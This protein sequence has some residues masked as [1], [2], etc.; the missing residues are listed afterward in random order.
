MHMSVIYKQ[1]FLL[2][3]L[4]ITMIGSSRV[5]FALP[6]Q[7]QDELVKS[8]INFPTSMT[9]MPDGR[10]LVTEKT[11]QIWILDPS[12][13]N[14]VLEPYLLITNIDTTGERGLL[15][16]VLDPGFSS[17]H[18]VYVSYH[19]SSEKRIFISRFTDQG[20]TASLATEFVV[21][22]DP[23]LFIDAQ[24]FH[25]GGGLSF[26]PDG[27]LYLATGYHNNTNSPQDLTSSRGKIIRVAS[28]GSIPA[29][30]PFIDG[31]GGNLDEI[32]AYGLRNPWRARWDLQGT[33]SGPRLFIGEVG[34]NN[35]NTSNEDI[36]IGRKGA[37]YGW[38]A[39]EGNNDCNTSHPQYDPNQIYDAP[40][41]TYEHAGGEAAVMGG[42]VY[43]GSQF[44]APFP[45]AYFYGDYP[46]Q[47]LRYLTFDSNGA[48]AT[49][50]DFHNSAG[51]VVDIKQG[52]DG[53][54]YYIQIAS[55][56][57]NFA[58]NSGALR[59]IRFNGGNQ[60]PQITSATANVTVGESPL[61]VQFSG[62]AAD[63]ENDPLSFVW[64]FGD[65]IQA[66]GATATHDYTQSGSYQARLQVSD[67]NNITT[68]DPPIIITV[69]SKPVVTILEP[70]DGSLFRAGGVV[71]FEASATDADGVLTENSY[72]WTINLAHNQH[73]HPEI[74]PITG[75][76]GSF[77]TPDSDHSYFDDT[78]FLITVEVTDSDGISTI[79][80]VRIEPEE[81][82]ITFNTQPAG[83]DIFID[84]ETLTS[85]FVYDS[86]I[87][88]N[89]SITAPQTACINDIQYNFASW[90]NGAAA[91]FT[92]A[93]PNQNA[94]LTATYTAGGSCDSGG[95]GVCGQNVEM[96]GSNDWVNIP[97]TSFAGDF[98]IEGWVKLAPGID[99][100]D[101]FIGQEGR[102]FD[103][104]FHASLARLYV[105][106]DVV[107]ANTPMQPNTWTHLA[108]TRSGTS[109]SL[110]LNGTLDATGNWN[111]TLPVQAL[112]R[113]NRFSR[114]S[115][116]GEMDE[117]RFWDVARS[118][119]QISQNYT[120]SVAPNSTGLVGYWTFNES[121]QVVADS[122]G[123]GQNGSLG[124]N[125]SAGND[126]PSRIASTA[127]FNENCGGPQNNAPIAQND[128]AGPIAVAATTTIQVLNNDSDS[129]GTLDTGSVTIVNSP[130][131]G[132]A[133]VL[134]SG[135]I[136]YTHDGS[137]TTTDQLTYT[138]EDN[139]GAISNQA[140]VSITVTA[141]T[142][143]LPPV[144]QDDTA[145]PIAVAATTTIQ[146]LNND[147]DSDG[148][149]DTNSVT[150]V[151]SPTNGT[152]TVLASG[153]I[154]Y[155]HDGSTTTTDQLTYT[156]EDNDGAVSNQATV[157]VTITQQTASCGMST[158]F[159]GSND[160][161][162]IPDTSFADDFTIEGWV[163]LAPG[164]DFKDAFIGQ[165][166][167]GPDINFHAGKARLFAGTDR[168]VANTEIQPNAWT[169]L[170]ITRSGSS[171]SLYLNGALDATGDWNGTLP[172]KALG[173]GNKHAIGFFQGE[174]DEVRFWN[175]ARSDAQI[176]Q[177]YNQSVTP[178][179]AGLVGYWTFNGA[180]QV[181]G[182]SSSSSRN[183]SLGLNTNLGNDDPSRITSTAPFNE[184][185][186]V[187]P[188]AFPIKILPLGDS[189][190]D[191]I[192]GNPSYRRPLWHQLNTSGYNVDFVGRPNY[193]HTTVPPELLDYDIDH[194][195]HSG[196]EANQIE[197]SITA[198]LGGFTA[199]IVLLHIGTND[200]DRGPGRGELVGD[201]I[202]ETLTEID[203]I[204]QKLRAQNSTIVVILA[205]IIPMRHYDT[206][207]FNDEIDAFVSARTTVFSPIVVVDQY[208]GFD[209][210]AD[211]YD[212]YH[213]NSGGESKMADK[214]FLALQPFL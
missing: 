94:T 207:I 7:F 44:P 74:G 95:S 8:G 152:A 2:L 169:H 103:I 121:G 20:S 41:F 54:L 143:N 5:A 192:L 15:D 90:S 12:L 196:F 73:I 183:G 194:E 25:H 18:F 1:L 170:A 148:T 97:D 59:R 210:I 38:P 202:N 184:N 128:A 146:V 205:K 56:F 174:M 180:G 187:T 109:V 137:T 29:D 91:S 21:W 185:C 67:P 149:L 106:T 209:A 136:S 168:V 26:G 160:W 153:D 111:E 201:T 198:W 82:D 176:S 76:S 140:T 101:A 93:V 113:G 96:D 98:T 9:Q 156:V 199:D 63:L 19:R 88:F 50:N 208:A 195:G 163:K 181:I 100:K 166:G 83:I 48:V 36:H 212:N 127:P 172:V 161:V 189:I 147:N 47:E 125:T 141:S 27:H 84:D 37:N 165:E 60:A 133:T 86:A 70:I 126:D 69:G 57:N 92:Y 182:D 65:G 155:T 117:V 120:Q 102:G 213:P 30:N 197:N 158:A 58:T 32:W 79:Q 151:N 115:F 105:G 71:N 190:T 52:S 203:G 214:W 131:N 61:T 39:C 104:N 66:L 17:N 33:G 150:I 40:L 10:M 112:G 119:T 179:S 123:S 110:Y 171:L 77:I 175:I 178:N 159:D 14:P 191:S 68:L 4:W 72:Q 138:V 24:Q 204:I 162:N 129:D 55:D 206:A 81:V 118:G 49:N 177:S 173:R 200:L 193:R 62:S 108:I 130:A 6:P 99:F 157:N 31:A 51:L 89:S 164:I 145:G 16:I 142:S 139:D 167:S 23:Q 64:L 87:G 116:Q 28:N 3:C 85:P 186:D 122:S 135:D 22:K 144:A 80:S 75:S 35:N 46:R 13:T 211:T 188:T 78:G 107:V 134:A 45:N 43:H 124:V 42:V 53:A 154:S 34:N 132:I 11:G 114:G